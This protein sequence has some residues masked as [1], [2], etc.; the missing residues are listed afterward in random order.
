VLHLVGLSTPLKN[1][2]VLNCAHKD[3]NSFI[4]II[5]IGSAYFLTALM[6]FICNRQ[7]DGQAGK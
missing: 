1:I 6:K 5:I 2:T 4:T 3:I 7:T